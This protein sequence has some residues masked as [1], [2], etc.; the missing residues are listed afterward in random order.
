MKRP[1]ASQLQLSHPKHTGH[2]L[3]RSKTSYPILAMIVLC[4]GVLLAGMSQ[5][6]SAAT[7]GTGDYV[8]DASVPGPPPTVAA[9]IDN[10]TDGAHFTS[11]PQ[12]VSGSCPLNSYVKLYRN[13][14]FSGVSE[15]DAS[16]QWTLTTALFAGANQLAA[17]D[18]SYTDQAGPTQ[19]PITVY[20]DAPANTS[21]SGS[22]SG[23]G[24][25]Q[26]TT[27]SNGSETVTSNPSTNASSTSGMGAVTSTT[28]GSVT[29]VGEPLVI[30]TDFSYQG[31]FVGNALSWQID[32]EGGQTPYGINIDW[33][34]GTQQVLSRAL[35]GLFTIS[36]T[37]TRPGGYHGSYPVKI[38][39]GDAAG[40]QSFL[41]LL[42]IVNDHPSGGGNGFFGSSSGG[43]SL[44]GSIFSSGGISHVLKYAW[45]SYGVTVLMVGSFWLGEVQ[46]LKRVRPFL[47]LRHHA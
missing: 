11:Q 44:G 24:Q 41:Q 21:G 43:S 33:G 38:S 31:V 34:D 14:F 27:N 39:V 3:P 47:R 16:G 2:V 7:S 35:S 12:T 36:H 19:T 18:Y 37:Y 45:P 29:A 20:Y 25:N 9:T 4:V 10:I 28:N 1:H 42:A 22:D 32:V 40:T 6:A 23:S 8:V 17:K 13:G 46:E 5:F 30:K 26:T 15:C